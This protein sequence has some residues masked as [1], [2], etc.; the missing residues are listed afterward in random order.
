MQDNVRYCSVPRWSGS[1]RHP[2]KSQMFL[3]VSRHSLYS[4]VSHHVALQPLGTPVSRQ[5]L[6]MGERLGEGETELMVG[7]VAGEDAARYLERGRRLSVEGGM[8][9]REPL[10]VMQNEL[11]DPSVE[12]VKE[13]PMSGE[14]EIHAQTLQSSQGSYVAL[15]GL[16]GR[17]GP[18]ADVRCDPEQ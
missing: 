16:R 7:E 14:D 5:M 15:Q 12:V 13:W 10:F 2:D 17:I 9:H 3:E 18:P 8:H 1:P 6:Q 4:P 11:A